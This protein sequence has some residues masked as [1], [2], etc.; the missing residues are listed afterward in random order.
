MAHPRYSSAEIAEKGQALY[1]REVQGSLVASDAGKFLVLDIETG[2]Y[3]LDADDLAAVKRA[4]AKH[5][6]GAFY[7]LRVG[8][9]AAYRLGLK[10]LTAQAC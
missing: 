4:R 8:H 10:T 3:E 7:V 1:E 5:P 2:D 9:P 6:D